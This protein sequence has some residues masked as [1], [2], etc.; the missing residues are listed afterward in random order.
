[1][2]FAYASL[3]YSAGKRTK[4][5]TR[6]PATDARQGGH[7]RGI[8]R[9]CGHARATIRT[10]MSALSCKHKLVDEDDPTAKFWVRKVV[11]TAGTR[12][13][14]PRVKCP[15]TLEILKKILWAAILVL[16][17]F[18]ASLMREVFSLAFHACSHIG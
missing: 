17:V 18:D 1:M 12:A 16:A 9:L 8:H 7:V 5:G 13:S 2:F 6:Y 3:G 10:Y 14:T 11:N 4:R 15:I